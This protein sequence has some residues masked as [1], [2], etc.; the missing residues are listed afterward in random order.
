MILYHIQDNYFELTN[1]RRVLVKG[2]GIFYMYVY[3]GVCIYMC[4]YIYKVISIISPLNGYISTVVR[5][6]I[7]LFYHNSKNTS[8]FLSHSSEA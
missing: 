3:I 5:K 4:V 8:V 6:E 7:F 2:T 1:K